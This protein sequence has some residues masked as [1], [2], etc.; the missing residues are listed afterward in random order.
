MADNRSAPGSRNQAKTGICGHAN[1]THVAITQN[2][3]GRHIPD[4]LEHRTAL[5]DMP[6]DQRESQRA[7]HDRRDTDRGQRQPP[8]TTARARPAISRAALSSRTIY[9]RVHRTPPDRTIA[10]D[11][12][13]RMRTAELVVIGGSDPDE[14]PPFQPIA[15]VIVATAR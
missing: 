7:A 6:G 15:H 5:T 4:D 12:P 11:S 3:P 1:D 8:T 2:M 9:G 13:T 14:P 10:C